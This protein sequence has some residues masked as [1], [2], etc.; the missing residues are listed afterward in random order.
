MFIYYLLEATV[1]DNN[2][3]KPGM[4]DLKGKYKWEAWNGNKGKAKE[5]AQQ[6]YV[7]FVAELKASQ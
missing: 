1:G 5:T 2:T 7:A 3:D 4:F 6:E